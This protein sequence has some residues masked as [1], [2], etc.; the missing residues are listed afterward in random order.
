MRAGSGR[1]ALPLLSATLLVLTFHPFRCDWLIWVALVPVLAWL[2]DPD[3]TPWEAFAGL[4]GV[5]T[6]YHF[7]FLIPFLSIGWWAWGASTEQG[8]HTY[9]VYARLF[10]TVLVAVIAV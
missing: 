10:M 3:V 1:Y 9:F 5:G 4:L 2:A 6:A 8:V 7:V